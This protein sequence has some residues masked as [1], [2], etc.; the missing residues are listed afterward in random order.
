MTTIISISL[1]FESSSL[2]TINSSNIAR[3]GA[4]ARLRRKLHTMGIAS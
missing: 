2:V 3:G 1:E 4:I